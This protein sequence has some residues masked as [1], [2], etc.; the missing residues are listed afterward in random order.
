MADDLEAMKKSTAPATFGQVVQL[1]DAAVEG[2]TAGL[3]A[4]GQRIA[5]LED[6]V[7]RLRRELESDR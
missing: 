2:F 6:T 1:V 4:Q 3:K 7:A 5:E